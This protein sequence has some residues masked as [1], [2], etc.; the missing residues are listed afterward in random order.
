[1][2]IEVKRDEKSHSGPAC[3]RRH[4]DGSVTV[5]CPYGHYVASVAPGAWANSVWSVRSAWG[6][7]IVTCSGAL[8]PDAKP[9]PFSDTFVGKPRKP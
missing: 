1:M 4:K 2:A 8:A 5:M 3:Y 6:E 7:D 9:Y